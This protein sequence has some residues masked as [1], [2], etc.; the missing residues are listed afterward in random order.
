MCMC[1]QTLSASLINY[2]SLSA[3]QI[4]HSWTVK[5]VLLMTNVLLYIMCI[6]QTNHYS[7]VNNQDESIFS[8]LSFLSYCWLHVH[9]HDLKSTRILIHIFMSVSDTCTH[10][11]VSFHTF[12]YNKQH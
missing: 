1:A 10:I 6:I 3:F 12:V 11:N 5:P 4:V 2:S 9:I 8:F 7:L